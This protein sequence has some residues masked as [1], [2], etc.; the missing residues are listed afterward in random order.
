MHRCT[1]CTTCTTC[2]GLHSSSH[3]GD[4]CEYTSVKALGFD[5]L[6]AP[7]AS[8]RLDVN[9]QLL[10]PRTRTC[11]EEKM[12]WHVF[13]VVLTHLLTNAGITD[14]QKYVRS[15]RLYCGP[16]PPPPATAAADWPKCRRR[17]R[18]GPRSR[19][20]WRCLGSCLCW[21]WSCRCS[22]CS[23][24]SGSSSALRASRGP[25]GLSGSE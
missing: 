3:L 4:T 11:C 7:R 10:P 25:C 23:C 8:T 16:F 5:Q 21:P 12:L 15:N 24:M 1:A 9:K 20:T 17:R 18:Q 13:R 14:S 6:M 22:T 2:T 19:P